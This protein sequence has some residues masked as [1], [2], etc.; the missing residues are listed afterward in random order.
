MVAS[1]H[2]AYTRLF[3]GGATSAAGLQCLVLQANAIWRTL[4]CR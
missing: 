4:V 3:W 1:V 2:D